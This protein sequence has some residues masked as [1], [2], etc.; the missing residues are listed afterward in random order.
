MYWNSLFNSQMQNIYVVDS[1]ED[2]ALIASKRNIRNI[3]DLNVEHN[4]RTTTLPT[5]TTTTTQAVTASKM[6]N[7]RPLIEK[8]AHTLDD[9]MEGNSLSPDQ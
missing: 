4:I 8:R 2:Q 3:F 9:F 6:K 5:T 1:D 7:C